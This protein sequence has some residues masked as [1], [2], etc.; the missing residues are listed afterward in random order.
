ME[1]LTVEKLVRAGLKSAV[2]EQWIEPLHGA[3]LR[4]EIN[5]EERVAFFLAQAC[6]ESNGF[7]SLEEDLRYRADRAYLIFPDRFDSI[8]D[9]AEVT[10]Q[11]P[12]AVANRV[13]ANKGGN[14]SESS[15][16]GWKY[17]GRG[18]F[19][20]TLRDNYLDA[21][22]ACGGDYIENPDLVAQPLDGALTSAHYYAKVHGNAFA[23]RGDFNGLTK[24][25]NRAM[26]GLKERHAW[27][28]R[29]RAALI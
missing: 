12:V 8:A 13:Y 2:A 16:D 7:L 27:L 1:A 15:G 19:N 28:A 14:G 21:M 24:A 5:T 23:D 11:G 26:L 6:H 3:F 9:A 29:I 22:M 4:F 10:R 25:V 18:P 20:L 17:R